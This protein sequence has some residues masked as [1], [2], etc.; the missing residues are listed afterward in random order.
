MEK[1]T[2]EV[3]PKIDFVELSKENETEI[4]KL[5]LAGD[6]KGFVWSV[7]R[8][9]EEKKR[10]PL[11]QLY[12]IRADNCYIGFVMYGQWVESGEL[13]DGWVWLDEFFIDRG[14]QGRGYGKRVLPLL[15]EKIRLEY[16]V[17]RIYLSV[18]NDNLVA[19]ALYASLGFRFT[20]KLFEDDVVVDAPDGT[21]Y[22]VDGTSNLSPD[23]EVVLCFEC[24]IT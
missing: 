15:L 23:R 16:G 13:D 20:G 2:G 14:Y 11:W 9:I 7:D 6:Q 19:K 4:G 17:D 8:C 3:L 5:S 12:G 22:G 18:F 10:F 21:H 24:G 1:I